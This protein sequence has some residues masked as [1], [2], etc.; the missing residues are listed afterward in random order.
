MNN[1]GGLAEQNF[2]YAYQN[3]VDTVDRCLDTD[4]PCRLT[5]KERRTLADIVR[6]RREATGNG[7]LFFESGN[8]KPGLFQTDEHGKVRV[9]V[10]GSTWGSPIYV[11]LDLIYSGNES[12]IDMGAA[13]A[14]LIH[15]I[16]HHGGET[17]HLFL[18]QLGNKVRYFREQFLE[19][20]DFGRYA[21]AELRL[22]AHNT[23]LNIE[24]LDRHGPFAPAKLLLENGYELKDL[25]D[26]FIDRAVCPRPAEIRRAV[27]FTNMTWQ[28]L[29]PFDAKKVRQP[30]TFSLDVDFQCAG[31]AGVKLESVRVE[32]TGQF[33][34]MERLPNGDYKDASYP[35]TWR[36]YKD[37]RFSVDSSQVRVI[38]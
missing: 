21:H 5:E 23:G 7:G 37:Y 11:N 2:I 32:W 38:P 35:E 3:L 12:L 19:R 36:L 33:R 16:G 17:D 13:L 22:S 34:M 20:I 30:I 18:D 15:E 14:I 27:H 25:T 31:A 26:D 1:G 6:E 28:R 29:Q 9:A 10:T 24:E 4:N 8:L